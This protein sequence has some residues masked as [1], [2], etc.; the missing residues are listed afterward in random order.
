MKNTTAYSQ[1]D[2]P[3]SVSFL[4]SHKHSMLNAQARFFFQRW[5]TV[6][7]NRTSSLS[8][9]WLCHAFL[10]AALITVRLQ[11]MLHCS[12][13]MFFQGSTNCRFKMLNM[14]ASG[15]SYL[16]TEWLCYRGC[17]N[18]H[19][20]QSRCPEDR[21]HMWR[22]QGRDWTSPAYKGNTLMCRQLLVWGNDRQWK[23]KSI[24]I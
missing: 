8:I 10:W 3:Q 11:R 18:W 6:A 2:P 15:C 9:S 20:G 22:S 12:V 23:G 24:F 16:H 14:C 21:G 19:R 1:H 5:T 13:I 17:R 7:E 4:W